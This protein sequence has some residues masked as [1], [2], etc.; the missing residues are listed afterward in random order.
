[1][2]YSK[3]DIQRMGYNSID[4]FVKEFVFNH[5]N[6]YIKY[7]N[8]GVYLDY[9]ADSQPAFNNYGYIDNK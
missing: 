3:E 9:D 4:E 5:T 7:I 2:F 8:N 6:C 1:M